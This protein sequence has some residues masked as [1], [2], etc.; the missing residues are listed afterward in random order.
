MPI[1]VTVVLTEQLSETFT[2]TI[3]LAGI[4][5]LFPTSMTAELSA[6]RWTRPDKSSRDSRAGCCSAKADMR[7]RQRPN[8]SST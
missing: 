8:D 3:T 6:R 4:E 2:S 1:Q 5:Q 7:N